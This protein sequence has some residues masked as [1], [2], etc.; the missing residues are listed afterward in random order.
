MRKINNLK[1]KYQLYLLIF[2]GLAMMILLQ[3]L[4][5]GYFNRLTYKRA[6]ASAGKLMEQVAQTVNSTASGIENSS[7]IFSYSQHV[8]ELLVSDNRERNVELY[9]FVMENIRITKS[10]NTN[11]Y[12][13]FLVN[14][15]TRRISDPIRDDNGILNDL[16]EMYNFKSRDFKKP[17]FSSIVRGSNDAFYYYAYIFPVFSIYDVTGNFAKI[18]AGVFV[19][20]TRELEKMVEV[21]DITENSVFMVLDQDNQVIIS[22]RGLRS[23]DLYENVFWDEETGGPVSGV[24]DYEGRRSIVQYREIESTGWKVVSVMPMAELVSDM[25]FFVMYGLAFGILTAILLLAIGYRLIHNITSPVTSMVKFLSRTEEQSLHQRLEIPSTNEV[26]IIA[27][28]I[29][30][31]LDKVESMTRKIVEN[32][33]RLY[34]AKLAEQRAELLALQSQINPH[35][36][37][38]TLNCL[39]N[40]GLAYNVTEVADISTAMS[41]IFRYSIKGEDMV[42]LKEELDCIHEYLLIMDIRFRGKFETVITVDESLLE[43]RTLKMVLQPIVENAMYHGLEQKNG[44]GRLRLSGSL[45]ENGRL[46]FVVEDDGKG[47]TGEQLSELRKG[48]VDYEN[49]GLYC[50]DKRSIGLGN[51][52]KRIKLQFGPEYGLDV[53]SE[54]DVGTRVTL[55][56]PVIKSEMEIV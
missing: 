34:E 37:Y 48:I 47:M 17:L 27:S 11:I 13:I 56:L 51:I 18:G 1:L 38:N 46:R 35:F 21:S 15:D 53:E 49:I 26:G 39:S 54:E 36:L 5:F 33:T 19:L 52:N 24:M 23:G 10:S 30:E 22:N 42:R 55:I 40:I 31:M 8:Q 4:N 41:N 28:S 25:K 14:N 32:Q 6:E 3:V 43:L 12:S 29:N 50:N 2:V 44:K 9:E 20:D 45:E 7:K 16:N